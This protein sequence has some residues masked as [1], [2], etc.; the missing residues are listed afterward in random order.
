[1]KIIIKYILCCFVI[2][3][4]AQ[5][6]QY[7]IEPNNK[8]LEATV[9]NPPIEVFAEMQNSDQDL[10]LWDV[11]DAQSAFQWSLQL[12]GLTE[13]LTRVDIMQFKFTEDGK[14]VASV[15][16]IFSFASKDGLGIEK[17]DNLIFSPAK[18]YI[19]L[20]YAG[21]SKPSSGLLS[22]DIILGLDEQDITEVRSHQ[23]NNES[24]TSS[25]RLVF[26]KG[27]K[28]YKSN[29][30]VERNKANP[31][32][33]ATNSLKNIF[34]VEKPV[35]IKFSIKEK[36]ALQKWQLK[37]MVSLGNKVQARLFDTN[38]KILVEDKSN[39]RGLY[40][41]SD[42]TLAQG[43]YFIELTSNDKFFTT[44]FLKQA[45][46]VVIEGEESEPNNKFAHANLMKV[47]DPVR[48]RMS[49]ANE[50]DYF[51][52]TIGADLSS[53][54]LEIKLANLD[55]KK[56][57]LC[58]LRSTGGIFQCRTSSQDID[59]KHISLTTGEYGLYVRGEINAQYSLSLKTLSQRKAIMEVEPNDSY[60]DAVPLNAKNLIK[61]TFDASSE[62]D[63]FTFNVDKEPQLWTIQANGEGIENIYIYNSAGV[64]IQNFG[65]EKGR[66]RVRLSNLFLLPGKHVVA[67]RGSKGKY[68]LRA[69]STG[70][71]DKNFETEPNDDSSRSMF[72]PFENVRQGI[73]QNFDDRDL[74]HFDLDNQQHIKLTITPPVDG[75]V[76]YK[77]YRFGS[78]IG[79][80]TSKIGEPVS[81]EGIHQMGDYSIKL[82][83][84]E[85]GSIA[86][87]K[88]E[89]QRLSVFGCA[90]DCE[91]NDSQFQAITVPENG[92]IKGRT[93][94][95]GDI[96]WYKIQAM[97]QETTVTFITNLA[98]HQSIKSYD[99]NY[100]QI[101]SKWVS[102]DTQVDLPD[103]LQVMVPA[104]TESY[105]KIQSYDK[106]YDYRVAINGKQ[107]KPNVQKENLSKVTV[108]IEGLPKNIKAFYDYGQVLNGKAVISNNSLTAQTLNL[109]S[110]ASHHL[111][112]IT[113][114]QSTIKLGPQSNKTVAFTINVPNDVFTKH[115]QSITVAAKDDYNNSVENTFMISAKSEAQAVNPKMYWKIPESL[116]GGINVASINLGA[117]RTEKD[118][119][120]NTSAIGR[121]FDNLFDDKSVTNHGVLYRGG[122]KTKKDTVTIDLISENPVK[123]I[124]F[125]LNPLSERLPSQYPKDVEMHLSTDGINFNSMVTA[126]LKP[127][128]IEQY[129]VLDYPQSAKY[130][131]LIIHN[132]HEDNNNGIIGLGEFKVIAQS[133][134]LLDKKLNIAQPKLGGNVI[135]AKPSSGSTWDISLLTEKKEKA[136]I[137]SVDET[138]WEWVIGFHHQR[139]AL[140]DGLKWHPPELSAKRKTFEKVQI[141]TSTQ[142]PVGPWKFLTEVSLSTTQITDIKLNKPA[143]ARYLKFNVG[144]VD[145]RAYRYLPESIEV[146][147]HNASANYQS[148]LGQW[149][150]MSENA[151][152]E[153]IHPYDF[154]K[155]KILDK[156][157]NTKQNAIDITLLRKASGFVQLEQANKPDWYKFKVADGHN[158]VTLVLSGEPTVRAQINIENANG[159]EVLA[160][161]EEADNNLIKYTYVVSQGEL[162]YIKVVEPP[163]NVIFAWDTS[164]STGSHH[165][166]IYNAI[167]QFSQ[168][169]IPGRDEVNF[170]PFGGELLM[171]K[172]YGEPYVLNTTLN[173]Y[174]RNHSSSSAETYMH[175]ANGALKKR[176]G[177]KAIIVITDAITSRDS[178][179]WDSFKEVKP[180]VFSL[181]IVLGGGFGG[182]D[183]W[184]TDLMQAWARVNQG[185]YHQV[186]TGSQVEVAFD[187]AAAKLREPAN[188]QIQIDSKFEKTKGPG[189][190]QITQESSNH[191]G[192][193]ELILDA[194][195]SMLKRLNG[196]RRITIA[197]EVLSKAVT[198]I[199]PPGTPVALRV[200]GNKQAGSCRTDLAIPL[201]PLDANKAKSIIQSINAKN[202]AKTPIADSLAKVESD[203]SS[204]K[205]KKIII[206]V[207]D[208][209]ETCD[210]RPEEVIKS[211]IDKG[212][213]IRLNIVGFAID[214]KDLKNQFKQWS[215]QGGGKYFD[216]NNPESLKQ[217]VTQA[218]QTPYSVYD[219]AGNLI[220]EGSI[221]GKQI[222]LPAGYYTIKIFGNK[223][224]QIEKYQIKGDT[225]SQTIKLGDEN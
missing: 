19:G 13:R 10:F 75:S 155:N 47:G 191:S 151:I 142:S 132:N 32:K 58:L 118:I 100:K 109:K 37:G 135:W 199:I 184:Q 62:Y 186:N 28:L 107:I 108:N 131:R 110:H 211:L 29:H 154:S 104:N 63:Y 78:H 128:G 143:W 185:Q 212:I 99:R 71:P 189:S 190:L 196:K 127:V 52:F 123:V 92:H 15:N 80:K 158:T 84:G 83:V 156:N 170:Q 195:G 56:L 2:T 3:A 50:Y 120:R 112:K 96:D 141:M 159:D 90:I 165:A 216:S 8:P 181:G 179:L 224:K 82:Q 64:V 39:A 148:I 160:V 139:A 5:I 68:L 209:E 89:L 174:Q 182:D 42:L 168:G 86:N 162:Y 172:W 106:P 163:R 173:N 198:E 116:L 59:L 153:K 55:K 91:P 22:N 152:Y 88:I 79:A 97:P 188:Y 85:Q 146:L 167:Q 73:L 144:S 177:S 124:G 38:D 178:I 204:N 94:T 103:K 45:V 115:S 200:F 217:S 60:K 223:I 164:G 202:L 201:K 149:G 101:K 166:I 26:T 114:A 192:A 53:N 21:T 157:N 33:I 225:E 175:R 87:Y 113:L 4:N 57:K 214:D 219:L 119:A 218:L 65:A 6:F 14:G 215:K 129:F 31:V 7:E 49:H 70:K 23:K 66:K 72:L 24:P 207:T 16:K 205:G 213:D 111:W 133:D 105:Y 121:G 27:G 183:E 203:L 176:I 93:N 40:Q 193:I 30:K 81:F 48:G 161:K 34:Y 98:E 36:E 145:S 9:I 134:S 20:S 35:W 25:Y 54:N 95:H 61:G 180:R 67:I 44:S 117:K 136:Y 126:Q 169:V 122:R 138:D 51:K 222:Q 77:I 187:R 11:T 125:A 194:S 76:T 46:G 17:I 41:F 74:Y 208:G 43:D 12:Q 1:M 69:F 210:G 137:R 221:N 220:K 206:L 18:Y 140:I 150:V 102:D 197:K 130:A 147:E 171:D